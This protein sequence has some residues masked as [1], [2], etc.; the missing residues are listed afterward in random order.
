MQASEK[1]LGVE[2]ALAG[3]S[4]QELANLDAAGL[5]ARLGPITAAGLT[6]EFLE[7]AKAVMLRRRADARRRSRIEAI[8]PAVQTR[9]P[10]AEIED[11]GDRLVVWLDGKGAAAAEPAVLPR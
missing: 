11:C 7:N 4:D 8:L 6:R 1:F 2:N 5:A 9:W 10:Q 3:T